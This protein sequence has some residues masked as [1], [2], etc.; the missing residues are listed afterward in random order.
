MIPAANPNMAIYLADNDY[1]E[2]F[3]SYIS[4]KNTGFICSGFTKSG[5]LRNFAEKN[6]IAILL[7]DE[8]S[9]KQSARYINSEITV[10]LTEKPEAETAENIYEINILQPV[11]DILREILKAAAAAEISVYQNQ[12]L[13]TGNVY[14][15]F[16]PVGRSLKTTLAI[17]ASQL[18][19]DNENTIYLNLEPDSGFT[20]LCDQDY[21]TD[22]SDL[23]F[24]IRDSPEN[25]ASLML[26][27]AVRS[28]QGVSYIPP[29][30]NPGDLFQITSEEIVS[31]FDLLHGNG[32][33]NVVVDMGI[34][35]PGFEKILCS[36]TTIFMPIRKDNMS[37]AKT[38][39]FLSYLR[40]LEDI[41]LEE[42]I[43]RMEPPF[44]KDL[45]MLTD[46]LRRTPI[47]K[48]VEGIIHEQH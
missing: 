1:L 7:T 35:L 9:F 36:S 12:L 45:P 5:N 21:G 24:Y 10:V 19:S 13:M 23:M 8:A 6:E 40:T 11:D 38:A 22:L 4:E 33:K 3:L 28:R 41:S 27:S 26:Q 31:L 37:T 15:F 47:G 46:D 17:T 32:Y 14:T 43:I 39:Q 2:S 42:R 48:Y 16:S 30:M 44:F 18:L 25:K 34:L 29:V 20:V